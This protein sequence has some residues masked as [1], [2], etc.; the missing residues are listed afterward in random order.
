MLERIRARIEQTRGDVGGWRA[1]SER[2]RD[3]AGERLS[4]IGVDESASTTV[5]LNQDRLRLAQESINELR[6]IDEELTRLEFLNRWL[7]R[8][9][10]ALEG[11]WHAFGTGWPKM[12]HW[13]VPG[14]VR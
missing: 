11:P 7:A 3:R 12:R 4:E 9:L 1:A 14:S 13:P 6:T 8:E 5:L 10:S 2:E